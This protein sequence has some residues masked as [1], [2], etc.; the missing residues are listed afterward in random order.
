MRLFKKAHMLHSVC[1]FLLSNCQID[2]QIDKK[3][4]QIYNSHTLI[5]GVSSQS[6]EIFYENYSKH[7]KHRTEGYEM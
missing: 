7:I 3:R 4:Q 5:T 6:S 1:V 2:V